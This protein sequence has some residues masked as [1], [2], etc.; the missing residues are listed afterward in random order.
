M[1]D[2]LIKKF[3]V[4]QGNYKVSRDP[5]I[6]LTTVLGSCVCACLYDPKLKIGG[7]NH[8]LL[9]FSSIEESGSKDRLFGVYLMELLLNE[10]FSYG[11][12]K[13]RLEVKLF[14]GGHVLTSKTDPGKKNVEFIERFVKLERLNVVSSSLRGDQGRAIQFNPYTGQARQ[15]FMNKHIIEEQVIKTP[16]VKEDVGELELF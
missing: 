14:G 11:V 5:D 10:M 15:K 16:V 1:T 8:F 9:P 2:N 13:K 3:A 12:V 7:M 6:L 4:T